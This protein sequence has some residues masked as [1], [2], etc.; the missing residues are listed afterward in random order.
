MPTPKHNR[1]KNQLT[2]LM[3]A[4]TKAIRLIRQA[5]RN[6]D[7]A[8]PAHDLERDVEDGV[9]DGIAVEVRDLDAGDEEDGEDEPPEIVRQL[10]ADLLSYELSASAGGGGAS[11]WGGEGPAKAFHGEREAPLECSH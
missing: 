2:R 8:I 4:A 11:G 3:P 9:G 1:A 10:A 7:A 5:G 6:T